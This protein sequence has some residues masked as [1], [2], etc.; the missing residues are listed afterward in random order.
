MRDSEQPERSG[1]RQDCATPVSDSLLRNNQRTPFQQNLGILSL[2]MGGQQDAAAEILSSSAEARA[3]PRFIERHNLQLLVF[4]LLPGS[5]LRS[6]LPQEWLA[7]L[8]RYALNHWARQER[9][10]RELMRVAAIF[11]GAGEPF[12]LLKGAYLGRRFFGGIDRRL[13]F[14]LDLLVSRRTLPQSQRLLEI[15]GYTRKSGVLFSET[16]TAYFTHAFDFARDKVVL[17]LHWALSANAAHRLDYDAI[18]RTRQ[19]YV[20]DG[21]SFSVLS[22]EYEIVFSLISIF[23][24]IERGAGRLRSF[25]DLYFIL[26]AVE[27]R[28]DWNGFVENRRRE[29]ILPISINVF[30]LFLS[31]FDCRSRFPSVAELV[32]RERALVRPVSPAKSAALL[33]AP[34]GALQNKVWGAELYGCSRLRL[35]LWWLASLPFRLAVHERGK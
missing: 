30:A 31:L 35:F 13:F 9:L 28:L 24:D 2:L 6:C 4:S 5:P 25:V 34:Q 22:D 11:D 23:K 3:F 26:G 27:G 14:D 18:W 19:S 1:D 33:E 32:E 21:R 29:K 7:V 8:R 16:L 17:D 15:A 12:I 10:L 20:I